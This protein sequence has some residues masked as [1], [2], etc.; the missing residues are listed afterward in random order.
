[1]PIVLTLMPVLLDLLAKFFPVGSTVGTITGEV[2]AVLPNLIAAGQTEVQLAT[3]GTPPSA[4]QQAAIDAALDQAHALL[5][6][7]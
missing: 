6:A 5:Q 4:A 2:A 1:M 3:Q 7:A